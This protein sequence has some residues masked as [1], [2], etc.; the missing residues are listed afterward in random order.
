MDEKAFLRNVA[1]QL[2]CDENRAEG[3]TFA[4]FQELRD[5][6]TATEASHVAAQLPAPLKKM[7]NSLERPGRPVR[8][9]HEQQFVGEVRRVAGLPNEAEAERAVKVVFKALQTLLGSDTGQEGEAWDIYSQLP[10]DL[11]RLWLEAAEIQHG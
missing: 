10:K 4:V 9:T 3:V 5:R 7:W 2:L 6:I 1:G 11:K 8:R